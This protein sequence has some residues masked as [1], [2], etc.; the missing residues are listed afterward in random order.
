MPSRSKSSQ[1]WLKEHFSDPYVKKAQAEGLR[2]RAV[3]KLEEVVE[4]DRL[5]KPGMVVVDLGAAPGS[6]SQWVRQELDKMEAGKGQVRAGRVIA[7]DILEM[8]T[9]AGVEFLHGDFRD[10]E[11]LSRLLETLHGE[12]VDLVL[13]DMAP[14]KSGMG[15]VDQPRMMHL[16][17]LAMDFADG[18]L[19]IGG[20]F[21]IKLFQ[22]VGFDEY[23]RELR[24][25][26][27]K[28]AIRKPAASR[29]RSPEVYALAQAKLAQI[30]A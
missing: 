20:T 14:N 2:S 10:D 15:A 13:S 8:P 22:G 9:L 17:E 4:R 12:P 24:R 28:V 7:S 3:Y 29:K 18:H 19:R 11:V 30:K 16:A 23:V 21:L 27:A 26:Y 5:L 1:R 25:R 6:W